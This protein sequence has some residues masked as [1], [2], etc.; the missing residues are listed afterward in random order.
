MELVVAASFL[1]G[2]IFA[3]FIVCLFLKGTKYVD[4]M[5]EAESNTPRGF[6]DSCDCHSSIDA[7]KLLPRRKSRESKPSGRKHFAED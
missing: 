5:D 4:P 2:S 7:S 1:A 3:S 6:V